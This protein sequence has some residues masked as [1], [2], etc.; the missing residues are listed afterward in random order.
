MKLF[1]INSPLTA[2]R[3][4][5][6][7]PLL[8][9]GLYMLAALI[10]SHIPVN[11][12]W[13]E[14]AKGIELFVESNGVHV[15][16]I[17]PMQAEGEDLS[18]LIRPDHLSDPMHYGTHAMIGWG[19][20]GVYRNAQTW[21]EVKSGDVGSAIVGSDDVLL[22]IYHLTNPQPSSYRRMFRVTPQQYHSIIGQI[23]GS[24][25]LKDGRSTAYPAYGPTN[26]FYEANG[27]YT[28]LHTCNEWTSDIL[29]KAGVRVGTWTPLAGGVM[30][31]FPAR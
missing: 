20:A 18:D 16:L 28:A 8:V 11:S 25:R 22:H 7:W 31:W 5:V 17:V 21:N 6:G 10:G 14:P 9:I 2:L 24:F 13:N 1:R 12:G 23:R 19:H 4:I 30:H 15:S 29:R 27:R 26:L 3:A